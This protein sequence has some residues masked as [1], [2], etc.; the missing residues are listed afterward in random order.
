MRIYRGTNP[1]NIQGNPLTIDQDGE[2]RNNNEKKIRSLLLIVW[3]KTTPSWK[4]PRKV[5]TNNLLCP[6]LEWNNII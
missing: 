6:L 2:E 3:L 1:L 5:F 4:L